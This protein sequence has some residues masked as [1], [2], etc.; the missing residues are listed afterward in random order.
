MDTESCS[1]RK[2]ESMRDNGFKIEGMARGTRDTLTTTDM[3][4]TSL[5]AKLMEK[6]FILGQMEKSTMESGGMALKRVMVSGRLFQE[7]HTLESGR[8]A[9]QKDMEFIRGEMVT[10]MRVSG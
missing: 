9:R 6:E 4:G 3:M 10:D 5:M 7:I 2:V 8:T 1:T